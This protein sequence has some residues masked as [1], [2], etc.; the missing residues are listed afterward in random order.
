MT[1]R[2]NETSTI[3]LQVV[4]DVRNGKAVIGTATFAGINKSISDEDFMELA[5]GMAS[6]QQYNLQKIKRLPN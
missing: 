1:Q 3:K 4:T 2:A 6:L 5:N